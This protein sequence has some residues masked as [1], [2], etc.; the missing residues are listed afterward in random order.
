MQRVLFDHVTP[1]RLSPTAARRSSADLAK[2]RP[3]DLTRPTQRAAVI[4]NR[5]KQSAVQSKKHVCR[6][7]LRTENFEIKGFLRFS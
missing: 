5:H 3:R 1:W 6:P 7:I 2:L 4:R